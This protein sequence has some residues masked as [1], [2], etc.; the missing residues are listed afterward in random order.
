M[1]TTLHT[2]ICCFWVEF[3]FIYTQDC[4]YLFSNDLL[5]FLS[6]SFPIAHFTGWANFATFKGE[7]PN[8]VIPVFSVCASFSTSRN[9][10]LLVSWEYSESS[11]FF[12]AINIAQFLSDSTVR[13]SRIIPG[14]PQ[15]LALLVEWTMGKNRI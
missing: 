13:K 14:E 7:A 4:F 9:A 10:S 11:D 8:P 2:D 12:K 15:R 5:H 6:F 3:F 1:I